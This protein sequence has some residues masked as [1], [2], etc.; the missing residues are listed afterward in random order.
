[1]VSSA[2]KVKGKSEGAFET[3][4]ALDEIKKKVYDY[5]ELILSQNREL[6]VNALREKWFGEDQNNRTLLSVIRASV[7]DWKNWL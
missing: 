5:K 6:T 4:M 2:G 3:N 1:M 7:M